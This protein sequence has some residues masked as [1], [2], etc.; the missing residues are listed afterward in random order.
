MDADIYEEEDAQPNSLGLYLADNLET[1][2][3]IFLL[4]EVGDKDRRDRRR[5]EGEF[6]G[7]DYDGNVE[8]KNGQK[9]G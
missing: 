5:Q 8:I 6:R 4:K 9:G 1:D 3:A 7:G 2:D